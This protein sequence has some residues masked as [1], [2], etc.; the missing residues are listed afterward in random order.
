MVYTA[1]LSL[2]V[3]STSLVNAGNIYFYPSRTS[4][5]LAVDSLEDATAAISRHLGLDMF[6]S[7]DHTSNALLIEEEFVAMP[8]DNYL[9]L[10]MDQADAQG[11]SQRPQYSTN[12]H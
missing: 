4:A 7:V 11:D 6:E 2:L 3:A 5:A 12:G 1:L 8:I 9:L 10:T